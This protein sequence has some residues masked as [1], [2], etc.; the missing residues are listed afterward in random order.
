VTR[1]RAPLVADL[2]AV[3]RGRDFRRLYAT[4]LTSQTADGMVTVGLTSFV[5]FSPERQATPADAAAAFATLLLPYSVVGPFAGVL[6][7]RWRRRQVLLGASL[8]RAAL[9]C[10]VGVLV[11]TGYAGV[12]FYAAGLAVLSVNR[13]FLS[14]LSAALPHVVPRHELVM[15][16]SV[17]TTSGTI[18]ALVGGMVGFGVRVVVGDGNGATAAVLALAATVC[19]VAALLARRIAPDALGPDLDEAPPAARAAVRHIVSGMLDGARHVRACTPAYYALAAITGHRLVYGL[20]TISTIL[21][22]RNYFNDAADTDAALSGLAFA[23]AA[24][25]AG[26]LLAAVLTPRRRPG[27]CDPARTSSSPSSSPPWPSRSTSSV[28]SPRR[29]CSPV[30]SSSGTSRRARRSAWTRSC[31]PRWRTRTGAGVLVLRRAL[32]RRVRLR[33]GRGDRPGAGRT[34]SRARCTPGWRRATP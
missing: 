22:Y 29:P 11:A 17:S 6:L 13:F 10:L 8:L 1:P 21:L 9:I 19:V 28:R 34:G 5:F 26:F 31:S 25:G 2:R 14:A 3:V 20:S 4:R 12:G 24:S 32:Q 23:V 15:A 33:L 18:A 16:N 7:D 27:T 30:P